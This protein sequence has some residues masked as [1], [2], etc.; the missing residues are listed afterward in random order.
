MT[1]TDG[2]CRRCECEASKSTEPPQPSCSV[3]SCD[4]RQ[5]RRDQADYVLQEVRVEGQCCPDYRKLACRHGGNIYQVSH[6]TT[7][8]KYLNIFINKRLATRGEAWTSARF[9]PAAS[10]TAR[11]RGCC[12]R[13]GVRPSVERTRSSCPPARSAVVAVSPPAPAVSS[14][15]GPDWRRARQ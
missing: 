10:E 15:T 4:D 6:L 7:P 1:W 11:L 12:L 2:A 5:Y 13:R 8:E 14:R 3:E 9:T